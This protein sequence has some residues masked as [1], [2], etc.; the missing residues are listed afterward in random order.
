MTVPELGEGTDGSEIREY[1]ENRG[2]IR[3]THDGDLYHE[4]EGDNGTLRVSWITEQRRYEPHEKV[5]LIENFLTTVGD[6]ENLS[7]VPPA[8]PIIP[9]HDYDTVAVRR[10]VSS[11]PTTCPHALVRRLSPATRH[12]R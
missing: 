8:V 12:K 10:G 4:Y 7:G 5:Q 6:V 2:R 11:T 3:I 1:A 9:A